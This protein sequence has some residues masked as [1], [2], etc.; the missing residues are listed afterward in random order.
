MQPPPVGP[1]SLAPRIPRI[2]PRPRPEPDP[3]PR[4][5]RCHA[6]AAAP[7]TQYFPGNFNQLKIGHLISIYNALEYYYKRKQYFN[8][9]HLI[10]CSSYVESI[11]TNQMETL[12]SLNLE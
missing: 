9:F 12:R 11:N 6:S 8:F 7:T 4:P 5:R 2:P 10:V 3:R 1:C